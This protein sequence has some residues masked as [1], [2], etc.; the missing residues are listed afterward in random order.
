MPHSSGGGSHSGGGH[1]SGGHSHSSGGGSHSGGGHSG[2]A[3]RIRSSYFKGAARYACYTNGSASVVYADE[4]E[5]E[6][7]SRPRWGLSLFYIPFVV[8]I[9]F[10]FFSSFA[11][12]S[13]LDHTQFSPGNID[14]IGIFNDSSEMEEL[15]S[16]ERAFFEKTGISICVLGISNDE[17]QKYY[18]SLENFAYDY[19]VTHYGD[20][21]HWIIVYSK[22]YKDGFT[23]WY[24]EGMQG[25]DTDAILDRS[26]L[27]KFNSGMMK[28]LTSCDGE[29][30]GLAITS[31]IKDSMTD[32]PVGRVRV[33]WGTFGVTVFM[34][35]F[36]A[37]H[38]YVMVFAGTGTYRH[39][40]KIKDDDTELC[41][42][43]YC[44]GAYFIGTV[45][46]C[47]HCGA[48]LK[49]T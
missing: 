4:K 19:Y 42:C 33:E 26:Y 35:L 7:A 5:M 14:R 10:M 46:K 23:D 15:V 30:E 38:S 25:D 18:N 31:V 41:N 40:K 48:P 24:Y 8:A 36:I 11:F 2:S 16:A 6:E 49:L 37:F 9:A 44:G 39:Y 17:W 28:A 47:P 45:L 13:K 32:L 43:E 29:N 3:V 12:V 21:A 22:A 27:E 34:A 1:S 20:E